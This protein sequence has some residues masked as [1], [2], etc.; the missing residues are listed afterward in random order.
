MSGLNVGSSSSKEEVEFHAAAAPG[1]R[2]TI[3]K[4]LG[5]GEG[6]GKHVQYWP[7]LTSRVTNIGKERPP[8]TIEVP[9]NAY[10]VTHTINAV[11]VGSRFEI[12]RPRLSEHLE[13][14][15]R[16]LMSSGAHQPR[17]VLRWVPEPRPSRPRIKLRD[18]VV[19]HRRMA[20][21]SK[22]GLRLLV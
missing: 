8:R 17:V 15:R 1:A 5:L 4:R 18:S 11:E 21:L 12:T 19:D 14:L 10:R 22:R 13:G 6:R 9:S 3:Q 2:T 16:Q 20:V 7:W